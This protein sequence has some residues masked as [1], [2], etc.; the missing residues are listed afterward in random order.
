MLSR[1]IPPTLQ[2]H[3]PVDGSSNPLTYFLYCCA[4]TYFLRGTVPAW[5][6][7]HPRLR[8]HPSAAASPSLGRSARP[9]R[10]CDSAALCIAGR[11]RVGRSYRTGSRR[12]GDK[13]PVG[14]VASWPFPSQGTAPAT[15]A[16][17]ATPVARSSAKPA[18][19]PRRREPQ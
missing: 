1:S 11:G 3:T 5:P 9:A 15:T 14:S 18:S 7:L 19:M 12:T 4:P 8:P 6:T 16:A 17:S 13:Q 2:P 10:W